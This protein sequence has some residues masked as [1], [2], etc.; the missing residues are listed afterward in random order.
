MAG[1]RSFFKTLFGGAVAGAVV[2]KGIAEAATIPEV[3]PTPVASL[4]IP[5]QPMPGYLFKM[6]PNS[7]FTTTCS[8]VLNLPPSHFVNYSDRPGDGKYISV[9]ARARS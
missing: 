6:D 8:M 1:R 5:A 2:A 4:P 3:I 7:C 9:R